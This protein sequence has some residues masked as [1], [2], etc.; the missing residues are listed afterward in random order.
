MSTIDEVLAG[1]AP[2]CVLH[3]DNRD[4][5]PTLA[6]KSVDH[7]ITDPPYEAAAHT[8]QRRV[9]RQDGNGENS[10]WGGRR[11]PC[12]HLPSRLGRFPK[13]S[14]SRSQ[15]SSPGSQPAGASPFAKWRPS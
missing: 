3:A 14:G 4:V 1:T 15:S 12:T 11:T 5:L 13:A 8:Q 10:K 6:A 2:Y 7:V 9:K